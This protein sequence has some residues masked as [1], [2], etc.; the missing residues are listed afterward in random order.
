MQSKGNAPSAAQ[1]RWRE[2]VR[3]LGCINHPGMP[4]EIHHVVG[5]TGRQDK[6]KIGHWF[7]LPLCSECHRLGPIN[8][9]DWPKRFRDEFGAQ[10]F[11][12]LWSVCAHFLDNGQDLPFD[13]EV[14]DAIAATGK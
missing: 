2:Q 12:F 1:K 3:G 6:V 9:T 11:L 14:V 13:Q 10:R 5:A 8:V 4:A 7:I